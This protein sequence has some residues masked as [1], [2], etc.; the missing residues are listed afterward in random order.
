MTTLTDD[1]AF[2]LVADSDNL[3]HRYREAG[4]RID[5][6]NAAGEVIADRHAAD[7]AKQ[8]ERLAKAEEAQAVARERARDAEEAAA[9]I[10][11]DQLARAQARL[12]R[13]KTRH[14][15]GRFATSDAA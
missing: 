10:D 8:A 3:A 4:E 13:S 5:A 11:P 14:L 12:E 1:E 2:R 9:A 7:L 6:I 15:K